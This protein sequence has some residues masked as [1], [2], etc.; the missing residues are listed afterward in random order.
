MC[1]KVHEQASG[2]Q[3]IM[4]RRSR[5]TLT[6]SSVTLAYPNP[7]RPQIKAQGQEWRST[8]SLTKKRKVCSVYTA[9]V[10]SFIVLEWVDLALAV[11]GQLFLRVKNVGFSDILC[12]RL[13]PL[14]LLMV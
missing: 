14:L 3:S 8:G 6:S 1:A 11:A 12:S 4:R 10:A 5:L 2:C 9:A 7:P 13:A